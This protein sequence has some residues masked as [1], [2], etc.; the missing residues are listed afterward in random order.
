LVRRSRGFDERALE[1]F[2]AAFGSLYAY[3]RYEGE[4]WGRQE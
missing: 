1:G 2:D 4:D 3:K